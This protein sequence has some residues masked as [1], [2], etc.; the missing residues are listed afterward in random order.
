MNSYKSFFALFFVITSSCVTPSEKKVLSKPEYQNIVF[1]VG[2]D[3]ATHAIGCYGNKIV[4]TP[5]IDKLAGSGVRFTH[6]YANSPLCSAS[7]QSM[8]TGRY[9]HASGV[10][11]LRTPFPEEQVSIADHLVKYGYK[12]GMF[13]KT[14]FNNDLK[15]GFTTLINSSDHQKYLE[16]INEPKIS[17]TIKVRPQW[18]PFEDPAAVWLNAESATSGHQYEFDK[19]TFVA[20]E[21]IKFIEENKNNKFLAW[22][23]FNEPHSPFNFPIEFQ[24]KYDTD[25]I[26]LPQTS[27][28][29]DRWIPEVFKELTIEERKGIIRSYYTSVEYLD[30]NVGRI[31]D[32]VKKAGIAEKTLIVYVGDHGYLLNHHK[33]FEKHMMWEE[34]VNSPLIINAFGKGIVEESFVEYIDLMPTLLDV[35]G[36]DPMETA[37]GKSFLPLLKNETDV[38]RNFVFSEYYPDN[39]AMIRTKDWK[40]IFTTGE[41]DLAQGYQTGNEPSGVLYRLYDQQEDPKEF[42][43]QAEDPENEK[44]INNLRDK[45][46]QVFMDTH[47]KANSLPSGLTIDEKLA[48][49]CKPYGEVYN[50]Y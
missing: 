48:F 3:H 19:G 14:H 40:Y 27:A 44:V 32:A 36:V 38:H 41:K 9:P 17:D 25:D 11:L 50:G 24:G 26:L 42:K 15:H 6:A 18:K 46:L 5:N 39:K 20:R 12:T 10:T 43:N 23:A 49:F 31:I 28:E 22:I 29:D 34:S 2:D 30:K 16:G 45:M 8:I 47:P 33:R 21:G 37:Q 1:I 7:R 35:I 13:G 4:K